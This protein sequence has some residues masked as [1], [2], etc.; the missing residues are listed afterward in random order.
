MGEKVKI[1]FI[2]PVHES[3]DCIED[4]INNIKKFN[5]DVEPLFALHVNI[6]FTNFD[7]SRFTQN[8][9][10]FMHCQ[11]KMRGTKYE[12]QLSP[13][14]RTYKLAKSVFGD[15]FEYV[16]IFHTSELFVRHG[17]YDYIKDYDMSFGVRTNELPKRYWPIFEMKLFHDVLGENFQDKVFYQ[18]V[19]LGFFSKE[20]FD[21]IED[22]SYNKMTVRCEELNKFF[23]HTPIEEVVMPTIGMNFAKRIGGNVNVMKPDI[24]NINLEGSLFTIK[25]VPRDIN[26]PVRVKVREL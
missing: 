6:G 26:H 16:K 5:T 17:F 4:T 7:E 11:D 12:S 9:V 22:V 24:E 3:N 8:N 20:L 18:G 23:S 19:E 15:N 10:V 21:I 1:L 2:I 14:L 13:L 25:S